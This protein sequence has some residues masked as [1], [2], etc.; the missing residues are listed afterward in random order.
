VLGTL[1]F[2]DTEKKTLKSCQ[3]EKKKT[4]SGNEEPC[5]SCNPVH[6]PKAE[7]ASG[8]HEQREEE[9]EEE[10]E[11]EEDLVLFLQFFYLLGCP[12]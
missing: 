4:I 5:V 1:N 7:Q 10:E 2:V 3:H 12:W 6:N 8:T 11:G 9:E